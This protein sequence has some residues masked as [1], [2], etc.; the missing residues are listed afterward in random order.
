MPKAVPHP[1]DLAVRATAVVEAEPK[2]E[3]LAGATELAGSV[4]EEAVEEPVLKPGKSASRGGNIPCDWK[5]VIMFQGFNWESNKNG[6]W[7]DVLKKCAKDLAEAGITDVWLPPPSQSVAPQGYLPGQ[8]YNLDASKYGNEEQLKELIDELHANGVRAIAD[9]VINHRCADKQDERGVW[10]IFEG[11]TPDERLD[12]GPWSIT[13]HDEFGDGTGAPDT[14]ED[15]GAA[16]DLD[17]TNERVQR[18]LIGWMK[19][20]KEDIGYDGWRYDFTKGFA[21]WAVALYNE[22]T[23][24][25]FAVGEYWTSIGYEGEGPAYNQDFHR[26][27]MVDWINDARG[28]CA[29]FDFTTKGILQQA[30]QGELWRLRDQNNFPPGLIGWMPEKAVTFLDNHDTGS[31]QNHW[32]FPAD[33]VMQGYAYILTHPGIPSIF[34]DHFYDWNLKEE[35]TNLIKCRK[36]NQIRADSKVD[37]KLADGDC[38]FAEIDC[39]I[40]VKIGSRHDLG[41]MT[42]PECDW[43]VVCFGQ[44]YCVWEKKS[45]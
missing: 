11:G 37:I 16:P 24:P 18:E 5:D 41:D 2:P 14:G 8:L 39:K 3:D 40:I 22:S 23:E 15:Y 31:T 42:P 32:P 19:W 10:C 34:Y 43:K 7:Y 25:G 12:W 30:V 13:K 45:Q 28:T 9:I 33:K 4:A 35:I 17:H 44:D 26:Q 21:G 36:H 29:S 20:L 6:C 38:Y 27:Q 1:R